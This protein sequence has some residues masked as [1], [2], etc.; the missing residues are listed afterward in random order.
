MIT[1]GGELGFVGRIVKESLDY[2]ERCRCVHPLSPPHCLIVIRI[3]QMVH[4]DVG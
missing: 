1:P 3:R 4:V 2:K